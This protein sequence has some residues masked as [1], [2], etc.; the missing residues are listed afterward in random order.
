MTN[1]TAPAAP[2]IS[3]ETLAEHIRAHRVQMYE[4]LLASLDFQRGM[5]EWTGSPLAYARVRRLEKEV[6][7]QRESL[8][9]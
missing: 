6:E 3:P 2:F 5:A 9:L 1:S 8:G 4:R 7:Y